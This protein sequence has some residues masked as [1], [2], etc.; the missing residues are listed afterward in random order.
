MEL[1]WTTR[2]AT[3]GLTASSQK[4][5]RI[6]TLDCPNELNWRGKEFFIRTLFFEKSFPLHFF[7][8]ALQ[9]QSG[10]RQTASWSRGIK[11]INKQIETAVSHLPRNSLVQN[12]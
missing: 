8:F 10:Y 2:E 7:L 4:V 11:N 3:F 12:I 9:L 5:K 6:Q 1:Q